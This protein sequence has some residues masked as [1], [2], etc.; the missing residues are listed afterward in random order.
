MPD[1]ARVQSTDGASSIATN[2]QAMNNEVPLNVILNKALIWEVLTDVL[3]DWSGDRFAQPNLLQPAP[4]FS[5]LDN[6]I[7]E[8]PLGMKNTAQWNPF[9]NC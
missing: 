8:D 5:P 9:C 7:V 2:S 4:P 3:P 6:A 1:L